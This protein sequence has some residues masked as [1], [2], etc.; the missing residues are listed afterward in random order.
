MSVV[1][2]FS[3]RVVL[4]FADVKT[5]AVRFKDEHGSCQVASLLATCIPVFDPEVGSYQVR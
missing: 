1:A 5:F 2:I 4:S 3:T